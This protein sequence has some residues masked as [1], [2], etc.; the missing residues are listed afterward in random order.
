MPVA[1]VIDD[2]SIAAVGD[3]FGARDF[4][5]GAHD[6][7]LLGRV[8]V[9]GEVVERLVSAFGNHKH[10]HRRARVDVAKRERVFVFAHLV[11]RQLAAQNFGENVVGIVSHFLDSSRVRRVGAMLY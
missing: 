4:A 2:D 5:D 1:A 7:R 6:R 9:A 8:G 10:M 11:A 3:V